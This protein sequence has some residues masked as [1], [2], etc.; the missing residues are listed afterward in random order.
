[1]FSRLYYDFED[2]GYY[3]LDDEDIALNMFHWDKEDRDYGALDR[4]LNGGG[5]DS[6]DYGG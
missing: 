2:A 5:D 6:D 3:M 1:M 4:Y